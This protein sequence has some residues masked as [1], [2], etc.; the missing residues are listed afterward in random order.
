MDLRGS[1]R[2]SEIVFWIVGIAALSL[3]LFARLGGEVGRQHSIALFQD[4]RAGQTVLARAVGSSLLA[5]SRSAVERSTAANDAASLPDPD[6]PAAGESLVA[7]ERSTDLP[8]AILSIAAVGLEVPVFEDTS[9]RNLNRGA[10]WVA[11]TAAPNQGSNMAI[12]AHRDG[13]F[14]ALK[15]VR[16]GQDLVLTS[17]NEV[18]RYRVTEVLIVDP[19]DIW[20]LEPTSANAVTLVTCYPFYFVG[21]APRRYIVRAMSISESSGSAPDP[22]EST[23]TTSRW[24]ESGTRVS[25]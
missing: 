25:T 21:S 10:G 14:R 18:Q 9:E 17:L 8:I 5:Q 15:D 1:Y 16:V 19:E 4:A 2:I 13:Y 3:V 20:V 7:T 6:H 24:R 22:P 23:R 12:A 11:G